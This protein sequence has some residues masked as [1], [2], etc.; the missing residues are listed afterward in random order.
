MPKTDCHSNDEYESDEQSSRSCDNRK[1][2]CS[3]NKS[4]SKKN[5]NC[6]P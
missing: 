1:Y 2:N 6:K 4:C 5:N 3:S